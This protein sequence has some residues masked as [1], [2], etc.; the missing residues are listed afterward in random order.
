MFP[1]M[2]TR[3]KKP[4]WTAFSGAEV[5]AYPPF[6]HILAENST[7]EMFMKTVAVNTEDAW[8]FI[9]KTYIGNMDLNEL[10]DFLQTGEY[11]FLGP[12]PANPGGSRRV[13]SILLFNREFGVKQVLHLHMVKE[14]E[15][16]GQWK[17]VC[18]DREL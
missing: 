9:S 1:F 16:G 17:I 5:E 4:F 13:E 18:M 10:S 15:P 3:L 6:I 14:P 7:A 12:P 11:K 8:R 2:A